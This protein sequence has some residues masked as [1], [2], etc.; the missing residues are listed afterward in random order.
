MTLPPVACL[1]DLDGLLL[2]T[3]PFHGMG[4][5][6]AAAQFGGE[7]SDEQLLQ[8]RGRRRRDCA[9]QVDDWLPTPIGIDALLA[10]QQPI[11]RAL[12]PQAP[13]MPGAEELVQHL[14]LIH[15]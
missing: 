7:L 2:D 11:V 5:R 12:L 10:V 14:S 8:L 9:Q 6:Q 13:A 4:W 1:F 15:I 3:E